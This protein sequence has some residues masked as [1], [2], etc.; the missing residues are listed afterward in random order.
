MSIIVL[1]SVE[2][3]IVKVSREILHGFNMGNLDLVQY[4]T[5]YQQKLTVEVG[6][7][8]LLLVHFFQKSLKTNFLDLL[9]NL[10]VQFI[11]L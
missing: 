5:K 3:G 2:D 10:L 7:T 11:T 1:I 8:M 9:T 4:S 6:E